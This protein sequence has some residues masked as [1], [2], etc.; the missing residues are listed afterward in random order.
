MTKDS[1]YSIWP[2]HWAGGNNSQKF[3][4]H[5]TIWINC[6]GQEILRMRPEPGGRITKETYRKAQRICDCLNALNGIEDP[7]SLFAESAA[8]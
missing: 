5:N 8:K 3:D 1:H 7:I 6:D 2:T 4:G